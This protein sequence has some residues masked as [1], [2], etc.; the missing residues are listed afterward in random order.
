MTKRFVVL[1]LSLSCVALLLSAGF[2]VGAAYAA[3]AKFDLAVDNLVKA[4]A[5]LNAAENPGVDP[6]FDFHRRKAVLA[7]N[8]AMREIEAAKQYADSTQVGK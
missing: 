7:I 6:P 3:D 5:L 8:T 4:K 2:F 1:S